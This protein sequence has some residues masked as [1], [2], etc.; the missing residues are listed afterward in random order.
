[1]VP[2]VPKADPPPFW[3]QYGRWL[4][5]V[6]WDLTQ[7]TEVDPGV[8]AVGTDFQKLQ[9]WLSKVL[10]TETTY[11]LSPELGAA[12]DVAFY[13]TSTVFT[14]TPQTLGEI[15]KDIE[16]TPLQTK[17]VRIVGIARNTFWS[18]YFSWSLTMTDQVLQTPRSRIHKI[19]CESIRVIFERDDPLCQQ[20]VRNSN[21]QHDI[22]H[23]PLCICLKKICTSVH[24]TQN[25]KHKTHKT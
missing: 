16:L 2:R 7:S 6:V 15:F 13:A 24:K 18:S 22:F 10:Q 1:V 23:I 5:E 3:K 14:P 17:F 21:T 8:T 9:F 12:L 20:N 11:Q 19:L 25:T 4:L